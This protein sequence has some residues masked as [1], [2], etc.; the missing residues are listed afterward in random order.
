MILALMPWAVPRGDRRV[1]VA[2]AGVAA[3]LLAALPAVSRPADP[4]LQLAAGLRSAYEPP[5]GPGAR[6]RRRPTVRLPDGREV[7][8][9]E[10]W[11]DDPGFVPAARALLARRS[12]DDARLGAWL[13]GTAREPWRADAADALA[14]AVLRRDAPVAF[15]AAL[16]LA[17]LA[18][19][20]D[21][22]RAALAEAARSSPVPEVRAAAAWASGGSPAGDTPLAP[23]FRRG[24]SWW[25]EG[26]A[27]PSWRPSSGWPRSASRGSRS[28]RGTRCSGACTIP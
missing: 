3:A 8:R 24:V 1:V 18:G 26:G 9:D 10:A 27:T 16:A 2:L 25:N 11:R 12:G 20:S 13:L 15:E 5:A 17:A 19:G 21:R 28:T 4:T 7:P 23:G 14:G 22:G 6:W